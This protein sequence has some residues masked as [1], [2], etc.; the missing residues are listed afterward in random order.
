MKAVGLADDG[1]V[2]V[3]DL[4][5]AIGDAEK[6]QVNEA[7]KEEEDDDDGVLLGGVDAG[8]RA[9]GLDVMLDEAV[10]AG[11]ERSILDIV[12]PP[13]PLLISNPSHRGTALPCLN[14]ARLRDP[15]E[16]FTEAQLCHVCISVYLYVCI[17]VCLHICMSV[18]IS[19]HGPIR[20]TDVLCLV[21]VCGRLL[22]SARSA[23]ATRPSAGPNP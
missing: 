15:T 21:D 13:R 18:Y 4:A 11:S 10:Q 2:A 5:A 16:Q 23:P 6:E 9:K 20:C 8:V 19:Y 3:M 14:A 7:L 1:K 12:S 17:S 22:P